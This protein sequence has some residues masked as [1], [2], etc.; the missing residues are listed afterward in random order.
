MAHP[1]QTYG[2]PGSQGQ[3]GDYLKELFEQDT[4]GRVGIF[5]D[6]YSQQRAHKAFAKGGERAGGLPRM[7]GDMNNPRS[8]SQE[9]QISGLFDSAF[10]RYLG[11]LAQ[12]VG[13]GAQGIAPTW[14]NFAT[15][16]YNFQKEMASQDPRTA[17]RVRGSGP[18]RFLL[19]R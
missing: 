5:R 7:M 2:A 11:S 8:R 18:A 6:A 3:P 19:N 16:Q 14:T 17:G 4:I 12:F 13:G 9:R 10:Q 15:N 1:H